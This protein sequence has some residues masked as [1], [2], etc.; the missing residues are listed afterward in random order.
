MVSIM[1][2]SEMDNMHIV[3]SLAISGTGNV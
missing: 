2:F 3:R 1:Q